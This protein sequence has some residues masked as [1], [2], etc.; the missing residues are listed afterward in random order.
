MPDHLNQI[1]CPHCAE[2]IDISLFAKG[3]LAQKLE[4][5]IEKKLNDQIDQKVT[6]QSQRIIEASRVD[7]KKNI[8][9]EY[10]SRVDLLN[11]EVR[12]NLTLIS[13]LELSKAK[14]EIEKLKNK[15]ELNKI[16]EDR[17]LA[18]SIAVT[19][20]LRTEKAN[21]DNVVSEK[22]LTIISLKNSIAELERQSRQGS[23]Q[24]QGEAGEI[25]IEKILER[26][27]PGDNVEEIRR[28]QAG[29]DSVLKVRSPSGLI[30]GSIYFE[31]KRTREFSRPWIEKLK[32][33]VARQNASIGVLVTETMPADKKRPHLIDGIWICHFSDFVTVSK[34]LRQGLI[35]IAKIRNAELVRTDRAQIMFDY[36]ISKRFAD[37]MSAMLSPI[38]KMS[39]QL[40][41]ERTAITRQW[42]IREKM[43]DEVISNANIF[44]GHL[45]SVSDNGMPSIE[46]LASIIELDQLN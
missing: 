2:V 26:E 27:F 31:A 32:R 10:K 18:V 30:S 11:E 14:L 36:L 38:F 8:E 42:A 40:Q 19:E 13:D 17:S 34:I 24:M 1:N 12:E 22:D 20:A 35:S 6:E 4:I 29:A 5:E 23:Q 39:E 37:T 46:G 25:L 21:N 9:L 44:H 33:D 3:E 28:G 45:V 41:K 43:I 7:L 15:N 16:Q